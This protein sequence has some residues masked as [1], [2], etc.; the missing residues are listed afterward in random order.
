MMSHRS[1][2]SISAARDRV[3]ECVGLLKMLEMHKMLEFLSLPSHDNSDQ[4]YMI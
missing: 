3:L 4:D 1:K 2:Q